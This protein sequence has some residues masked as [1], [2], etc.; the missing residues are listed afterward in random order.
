MSYKY[1]AQ[2]IDE[3]TDEVLINLDES[4]SESL[5]EEMGKTKWTGVVAQH[6][7][8]KAEEEA[9]AKESL[10]R[11]IEADKDADTGATKEDEND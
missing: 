3:D 11:E 7:A 6:E 8:K 4:S 10:A 9:D 2:I 1:C 5:E